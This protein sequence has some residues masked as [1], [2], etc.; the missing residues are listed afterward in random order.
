M[1]FTT[2]AGF[3]GFEGRG[4]TAVRL[5]A[6]GGEVNGDRWNGVFGIDRVP[7]L[8]FPGSWCGDVG[9]GEGDRRLVWK[10]RGRGRCNSSRGWESVRTHKR[11]FFPERDACSILDTALATRLDSAQ[12][13]RCSLLA[14]HV[15]RFYVFQ[16]GCGIPSLSWVSPVNNHV[17]LGGKADVRNPA[18][19]APRCW[20]VYETG[21]VAVL[22]VF[23]F[24]CMC[25]K[26]GINLDSVCPCMP[27]GS[28]GRALD[29][30]V[31]GH[32]R[33]LID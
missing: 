1:L 7:R 20:R 28:Y 33:A 3:L 10:H 22:Q 2:L 4:A 18:C 13:R 16:R 21:L 8:R 26:C 27:H 15:P 5:K 31:L 25:W 17:F 12:P 24:L 23:F 9:G 19:V 32:I 6:R 11:G 29:R 30:L 14:S